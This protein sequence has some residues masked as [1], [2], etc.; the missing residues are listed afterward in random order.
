MPL[1]L[2]VRDA[3]RAVRTKLVNAVN[4]KA[5]PVALFWTSLDDSG[6]LIEAVLTAS[7]HLGYRGAVIGAMGGGHAPVPAI[8]A[9]GKLAAA[10]PTIVA[11]RADGGPLLEKT[12]GGPGSEVACSA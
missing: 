11:P 5:S 9:L 8:D 7:D 2:P 1:S 6:R 12:Y 10:M 4:G 3:L